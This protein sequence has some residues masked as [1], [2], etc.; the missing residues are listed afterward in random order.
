MSNKLIIVGE[1][2]W[3][4]IAF[5]SALQSYEKH[6]LSILALAKT[7]PYMYDL[8]TKLTSIETGAEYFLAIDGDHFGTIR[9][10]LL[11]YMMQIGCSI[12]SL[13]PDTHLGLF[14]MK[15]NCLIHPSATV[16]IRNSGWGFNVL[17]GPNAYIGPN[18]KLGRTVTI[19]GN[20]K[21]CSASSIGKNVSLNSQTTVEIGATIHPFSSIDC[22][23]RGEIVLTNKPGA[24][25]L[26]DLFPAPVI[27]SDNSDV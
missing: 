25:Y 7:G 19:S 22:S 14:K 9:E 3:L 27:F 6:E 15:Q 5:D 11:S 23:R 13:V 20:S 8:E 4:D 2:E 10:S 17:V 1:G 12:A 26:G 16:S 24:F 21:I 18:V